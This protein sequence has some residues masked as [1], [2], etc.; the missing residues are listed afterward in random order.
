[1]HLEDRLQELYFKS[2]M[3]SEYLR[4]QMRVHVKELG[5]VLGYVWGF[6]IALSLGKDYSQNCFLEVG[7]CCQLGCSIPYKSRSLASADLKDI[8]P[9]TITVSWETCNLL[10][11]CFLASALSSKC[12]DWSNTILWVVVHYL[13]IITP[14]LFLYCVCLQLSVVVSVC[15]YPWEEDIFL[16]C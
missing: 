2:R 12:A 6:L 7:H 13:Y 16:K 10:E 5:V 8:V 11:S 14:P 4:G 1:M 9:Y 15:S 3:L